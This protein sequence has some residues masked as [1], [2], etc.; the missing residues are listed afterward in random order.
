[1][2]ASFIVVVLAVVL[3]CSLAKAIASSFLFM[4]TACYIFETP[5]FNYVAGGVHV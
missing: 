1:M 3:L 4:R 5:C 2:S